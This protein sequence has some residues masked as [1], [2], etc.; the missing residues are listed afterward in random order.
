MADYN[1]NTTAE[2]AFLESLRANGT[3]SY[4]SSNPTPVQQNAGADDEDDEDYD[5]TSFVTSARAAPTAAPTA[6]AQT[7]V[8]DPHAALKSPASQTDAAALSSQGAQNKK[9]RT[10]GGFAVDD[11]DEDENPTPQPATAA[12]GGIMNVA[13]GSSSTPQRSSTQTPNN[14]TFPSSETTMQKAAQVP[15][16][17]AVAPLQTQSTDPATRSASADFSSLRSP[18]VR[19]PV[20]ADPPATNGNSSAI[21]SSLPKARLPQDRV[22][23]LEDRIAE[24]PRG[25]MDAWLSLITEHQK[26]N[27]FDEARAV[28][29]RFFKVFPQAVRA[30]L[31][32]LGHYP[33]LTHLPG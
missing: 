25:D 31:R 8:F 29:E 32:L 24:D 13:Q 21:S 20:K 3:N 19:T 9:P 16:G 27:K 10:I 33:M 26:R 15:S 17:N 11:D 4:A 5:P 23:I 1:Q 12:F 30:R 7:S 6:T 28:Y 14:T 2:L 18:A 22:G